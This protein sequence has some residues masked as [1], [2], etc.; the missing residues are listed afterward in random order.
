MWESRPTHEPYR[1]AQAAYV[2]S[3]LYLRARSKALWGKLWTLLTGHS[4]Q[5][6]GL[7]A[8]ES[9]C[10]VQGR[11]HRPGRRM[12]SIQDIRGSEGRCGDFDADFHPLKGHTRDRWVGI[13][14]AREMATPLP[15]VKLIQIADLYFVRDGHH[16]ISVA[17]ALGQEAIEA[18]VTAWKVE[19]PLPWERRAESDHPLPIIG[20]LAG[21][22]A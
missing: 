2:A 5:L 22:P 1:R 21:Q 13:A 6:V 16:R 18:E 17:R 8:V 9:E 11:T 10:A 3:E 20:N 15:P 7:A 12:V 19:G 4:R 14:T